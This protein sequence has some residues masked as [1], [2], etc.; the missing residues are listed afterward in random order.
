MNALRIPN[1]K[2]QP[3]AHLLFVGRLSHAILE[4]GVDRRLEQSV[5]VDGDVLD[6]SI[7][8]V[9]GEEELVARVHARRQPRPTGADRKAAGRIRHEPSHLY[10]GRSA[11]LS[12]NEERSQRPALVACQ[13]HMRGLR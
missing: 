11:L 1:V 6:V 5:I 8:R 12:V 13:H 10:C 4:M 3:I 2:R 7:E 9:A